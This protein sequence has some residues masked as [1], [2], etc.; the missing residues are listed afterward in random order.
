MRTQS[1]VMSDCLGTSVLTAQ[2]TLRFSVTKLNYLFIKLHKIK[3][4]CQ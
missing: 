1:E 2:I 4:L 3:K